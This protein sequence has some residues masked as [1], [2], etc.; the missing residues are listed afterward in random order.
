MFAEDACAKLIAGYQAIGDNVRKAT[1]IGRSGDDRD[2][3]RLVDKIVTLASEPYGDFL[4]VTGCTNCCYNLPFVTS[5]EWETLYAHMLKLPPA[6]QQT[7]LQRTFDWFGAMLG[8]MIVGPAA[9]T[10]GLIA[11][12]SELSD[13][14]TTA[15]HHCPLLIDDRCSTY[16]GRPL[17]CRAYGHFMQ[18]IDEML[19]TPYMCVPAQHHLTDH[20][21]K[22]TVLPLYNQF[23]ARLVQLQGHDP[24][25]AFIPLWIASH[26]TEGKLQDQINT[27]PDFASAVPQFIATGTRLWGAPAP[28]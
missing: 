4:C 20:F 21:P 23:G 14:A 24:A 11:M 16:E 7:I 3:Y 9:D 1:N 19:R 5:L 26:A 28:D 27:R 17:P 10:P 15:G 25:L 13:V 22:D 12:S 2:L 6:A 18:R 8:R